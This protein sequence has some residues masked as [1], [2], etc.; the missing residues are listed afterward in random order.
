MYKRT[1]AG[2]DGAEHVPPTLE[3][4]LDY[5]AISPY[6]RPNVGWA[7]DPLTHAFRDAFDFGLRADDLETNWWQ[8]CRKS[9]TPRQYKPSTWDE[10]DDEEDEDAYVERAWREVWERNAHRDSRWL[11]EDDHA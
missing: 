10:D 5:A 6:A 3:D 8:A 1:P 2:G 7:S 11:E 9:L 4:T